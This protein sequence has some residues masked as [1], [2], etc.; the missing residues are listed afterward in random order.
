MYTFIIDFSLEMLDLIQR[1]Y[2]ADESF[3]SL[4]FMVHTRLWM[5]QVIVQ[6][7]LGTVTPIALLGLTQVLKLTETHSQTNLRPRRMSHSNRHLRHALECCHRRSALLEEFPRIHHVQD[8]LRHPRGIID[9]N[10]AD[11]ASLC[12][13]LGLGKTPAAL[14]RR[15]SHLRLRYSSGSRNQLAPSGQMRSCT[16]RKLSTTSRWAWKNSASMCAH[17]KA[18]SLPSKRVLS[19]RAKQVLHEAKYLRSRRV[20]A[21]SATSPHW[22]LVHQKRLLQR[23]R[24][25]ATWRGFPPVEAP[26]GVVP[27]LGKAVL[28]IAGA[29]MLRAVAESNSVPKL[30]VLFVAILYACIWMVWAVRI[31]AANRLAGVTYGITSV[32]I[33]SPLLWESTVRFQVLSPALAAAVTV[34]FVVLTIALAWR[35]DLQLI[36]WIATLASV[37]TVLALIIETRE[38]VPLTAALLA[39]ALV[40]EAAACLGHRLTLRAIPALAADFAVWLLVFVLTSDTIPE[41]YHPAAGGTIATLCFLLLAIYGASIGVRSFALRQPITI[42]EIGQAVIA[43]ALASYGVL[44]ATHGS[45]A[46]P[47]GAFFMLLAAFCYWGALSRFTDDAQARNRR[48]FATWAATLLLAGTF[49]LFPANLQIPF[50]CASAAAATLVYT[51][52]RKL[53]LGM[54]ASFYLAAATVFSTLP[55]YAAGALAENVPGVPDWRVWMVAVSAAIVLW[56]WGVHSTG[57]GP[58]PSIVGDARCYRWLHCRRPCDCCDCRTRFPSSRVSRIEPL[59]D[60]HGC[61]LRRRSRLRLPWFAAKAGRAR[62]AR[63][64]NCRTGHLQTPRRRP[65]FRKR[66]LAG[67]LSSVLR[68]DPDP[69]PSSHE[70]SRIRVIAPVCTQ[71][72]VERSVKVLTSNCHERSNWH[73]RM[74]LQALGRPLLSR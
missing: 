31:H 42:F 20:P 50:L 65:A 26:S 29:Y 3:R 2:E 53:S 48:V 46:R 49:L 32:L 24:P 18:A 36:P 56:D 51:R 27:I 1:I 54:H 40:T 23:P 39:V 74:A 5:S 72:T 69:A 7:L 55:A 62:M 64:R 4:D 28:G 44:R 25:P 58:S 73:V 9:G 12:H 45:T 68:I 33:L 71:K 6:I 21:P 67:S 14:A 47:L 37:I 52:T 43:F 35:R 22:K 38:L 59:R 41:G 16:C 70:T 13:S 10:R 66:R 61:D 15:A 11:A 57:S 34:A 63:I 30:P 60:S 19:C 17:W 8:G